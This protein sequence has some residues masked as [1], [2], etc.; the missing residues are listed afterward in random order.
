MYILYSLDIGTDLTSHRI[1]FSEKDGSKLQ[2]FLSKQ[3][4]ISFG[5]PNAVSY[6]SF[7]PFGL[8][9]DLF[10]VH[11]RDLIVLRVLR[12]VGRAYHGASDG[13]NIPNAGIDISRIPLVGGRLHGDGH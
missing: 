4:T 10:V 8:I 9:V 5:T 12:S 7:A 11:S 13:V 1:S 3:T 2:R 6:H